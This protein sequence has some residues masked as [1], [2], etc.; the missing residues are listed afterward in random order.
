MAN[1]TYNELKKMTFG[2]ELEY[3]GIS[4]HEAVTAI[5]EATGGTTNWVAE[6]HLHA[7]KVVMADGRAWTIETDASVQ[8]GCES[9]SP[10]LTLDD[11][12]MLQ[13]VIR[14]LRKHG[15]KAHSSCG[16]HIHIGAK[17]LTALDVS[18][19][20]RYWWQSED[21]FVNGC[22]TRAERVYNWC[23][24]LNWD[25]VSKLNKLGKKVTFKHLTEAFYGNCGRT[26][27]G[28]RSGM[29][30]RNQHYCANRY[31]ALNLHNLLQY[32][33]GFG[34]KPTIEFRLFEATTHA[35]EVKA[36]V[37]FALSVVNHATRSS[38]VVA[39]ESKC[40]TTNPNDCW[41]IRFNHLGWTGEEFKTARFHFL[42]RAVGEM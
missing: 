24:K 27:D 6:R 38:R 39:T 23:R 17:N 16:L 5:M 37:L 19:V 3:S 33:G 4:Q 34:G 1:A 14:S 15:A 9:V 2:V 26:E 11:M 21:I 12:D 32:H 20:A 10:I 13:S 25:F 28:W 35:G 7:Y 31:S 8:N 42:K 18:K 29:R 30:N 41:R 36:N 22:G 40:P